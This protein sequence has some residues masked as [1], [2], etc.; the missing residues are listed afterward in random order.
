MRRVKELLEKRVYFSGVAE[1][2]M[3]QNN[4]KIIG[5]VINNHKK[6]EGHVLEDVFV[7]ASLY[8][9]SMQIEKSGNRF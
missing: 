1:V 2:L 8:A 4:S 9:L 3:G 7:S 5:V 6:Y